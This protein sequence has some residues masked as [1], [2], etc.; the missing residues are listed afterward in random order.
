MK[1]SCEG[2]GKRYAT[3]DEP[4]PGRVYKLACKRCGHL[5]VVRAPATV[6][7]PVPPAPPVAPVEQP[8]PLT[9]R[10]EPELEERAP[11]AQPSAATLPDAPAPGAPL[12]EPSVPEMQLPATY[13]S[14]MP[15]PE[16]P[17]PETP[18]PGTPPGL[19]LTIARPLVAASPAPAEP[20]SS[21]TGEHATRPP[22]PGSESPPPLLSEP[23]PE[24][25][26]AADASDDG[27]G[28]GHRRAFEL[29]RMTRDRPGLPVPLL[30][31]GLLVLVAIIAVALLRPARRETPPAQRPAAP[32][33]APGAPAAPPAPG[34]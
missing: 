4:V 15:P 23:P 3:A 7:A 5:I 14:E 29:S 10:F 25:P 22:R 28:P 30:V 12:P 26:A 11:A 2:C 33:S 8:A 13:V 27:V 1:F 19:E 16:K 17:F 9:R 6:V 21:G 24:V 18:L 31:L 34:R 20:A 32:A